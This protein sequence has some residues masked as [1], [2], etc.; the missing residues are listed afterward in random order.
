MKALRILVVEDEFVTTNA[1]EEALTEAGYQIS[2]TA[3]SAMEALEVLEQEDTDIAILDINI[4][5]EHDGIWLAGQINESYKI[6][7]IFLTAY[8]DQQTVQK[9]LAADTYGYL[10][11]PFNQIDIYTAIEVAIKNFEKTTVGTGGINLTSNVHE[12]TI[13]PEDN[14]FVKESHLYSRIRV[15]DIHFLKAED[16]GVM[17]FTSKKEMKLNHS[18][19][20]LLALL[21]SSHFVQTHRS[22]MVNIHQVE[23]IGGNFLKISGH[24]IPIST[25]R[26]AEVLS[27][28]KIL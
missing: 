24:E 1:I 15:R 14:L 16:R 2:G 7:H 18:F 9:A 5:G 10:V 12:H 23:H 13:S 17:A 11:K 20:S 21:P 19:S 6:P 28:F 8:G 27:S 22:Y 26:K 4:Q 3:S 25:Q